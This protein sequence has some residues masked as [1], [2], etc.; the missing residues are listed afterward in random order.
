MG[1]QLPL[2]RFLEAFVIVNSDGF[3]NKSIEGH[4]NEVDSLVYLGAICL[5]GFCVP[6]A[7]RHVADWWSVPSS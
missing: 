7:R 4:R 6:E 2:L 5:A 3:S 1:V